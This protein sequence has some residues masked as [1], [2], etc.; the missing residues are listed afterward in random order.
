M[1]ST[2]STRNPV[3][4]SLYSDCLALAKEQRVCFYTF[5]TGKIKLGLGH[6][7]HILASLR[8]RRKEKTKD[9]IKEV[10]Q[11]RES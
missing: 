7:E 10:I 11:R 9:Q 4:L 2:R 1:C 3:V 8:E 6:E 5:A